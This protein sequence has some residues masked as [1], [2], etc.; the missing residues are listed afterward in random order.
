MKFKNQIKSLLIII[1]LLTSGCEYSR[2]F[3]NFYKIKMQEVDNKHQSSNAF[4]IKILEAPLYFAFYLLGGLGVVFDV[5]NW[6]KNFSSSHDSKCLETLE[7]N[8]Y[9]IFGLELKLENNIEL[10]TPA[11]CFEEKEGKAL[12]IV[13]RIK[14]S[15]YKYEEGDSMISQIFLMKHITKLNDNQID[16]IVELYSSKPIIEMMKIKYRKNKRFSEISQDIGNLKKYNNTTCKTFFG[17]IK[18]LK[19]S[20]LPNGAEYLIQKDFYKTCHIKDIN[21]TII[22]QIS[23]RTNSIISKSVN[24]KSLS[25]ELNKI[26]LGFR[27]ERVILPIEQ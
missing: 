17:A 5:P 1:I 3:N 18:D 11:K 24:Q 4:V 6:K 20:N 21:L 10:M 8:K 27:S 12:S 16:N 22:T 13:F 26:L 15:E 9:K 7:N 14:K 25:K 19:P 2:N 23:S